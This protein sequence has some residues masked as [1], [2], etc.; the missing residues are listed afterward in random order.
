[1]E[2][3]VKIRSMARVFTFGMMAV[4]KK[5]NLKTIKYMEK[6]YSLTQ[7]GEGENG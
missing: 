2:I 1:M 5:G 3:G 4:G 6:H 7:M